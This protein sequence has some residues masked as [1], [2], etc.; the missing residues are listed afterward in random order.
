MNKRRDVTAHLVI[1]EG[2]Q[3]RE[4]MKE[5]EV[6]GIGDQMKDIT[7]GESN[8]EVFVGAREGSEQKEHYREGKRTC[9]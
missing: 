5:S 8:K 3:G 1:A 6:A 7:N 4:Q 9:W 2:V